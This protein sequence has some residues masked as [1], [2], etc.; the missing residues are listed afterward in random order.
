MPFYFDHKI[1]DYL[2][3]FPVIYQL[4]YINST[5]GCDRSNQLL[6]DNCDNLP[7]FKSLDEKDYDSQCIIPYYKKLNI[8]IYLV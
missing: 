2:S 1:A 5:V 8:R 6:I 3:S 4:G 7:T